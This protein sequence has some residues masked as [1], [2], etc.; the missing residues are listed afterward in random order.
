V[1]FIPADAPRPF[2]VMRRR[3]RRVYTV[4]I[5][6]RHETYTAI[7]IRESREYRFERVGSVPHRIEA[8]AHYRPTLGIGRVVRS[9]PNPATAKS[10][11]TLPQEVTAG[12]CREV[13]G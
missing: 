2:R 13:V 6:G 7:D 10:R 4:D 3:G 9:K 8:N 11:K 12:D 1:S 5:V